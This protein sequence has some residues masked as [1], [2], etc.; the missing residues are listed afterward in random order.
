MDQNY[1]D[2][3]LEMERMRRED[4]QQYRQDALQRQDEQRARGVQSELD[5]IQLFSGLAPL[6]EQERENERKRTIIEEMRGDSTA[7]LQGRRAGRTYVAPSPFE[8]LAKLGQAYMARKGGQKAYEEEERLAGERMGKLETYA[9]TVQARLP[10]D[11]AGVRGGGAPLPTRKPKRALSE[12][13]AQRVKKAIGLAGDP[14][15]EE[16]YNPYFTGNSRG[17]Q[18]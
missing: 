9:N 2:T 18:T 13:D 14:D 8:G 4:Q 7:P 16:L 6:D 10:E 5:R 1:Y 11:M 12:Y 3:I 15:E 17:V